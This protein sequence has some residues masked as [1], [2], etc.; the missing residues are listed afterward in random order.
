[1]HR[2]RTGKSHYRAPSRVCQGEAIPAVYHG[3]RLTN[4]GPFA[5]HVTR[6]A[7]EYCCIDPIHWVRSISFPGSTL[8]CPWFVRSNSFEGIPGAHPGQPWVPCLSN[9]TG[10][11]GLARGAWSHHVRARYRSISSCRGLT[12]W[13]LQGR[14]GSHPIERTQWLHWVNKQ[15]RKLFISV[16]W[17]VRGDAADKHYLGPIKTDYRKLTSGHLPVVCTVYDVQYLHT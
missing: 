1:M 5:V 2:D 10:R 14:P 9:W 8:V 7:L 6:P 15:W 11:L 3:E 17:L 12:R 4:F 16:F 13:A